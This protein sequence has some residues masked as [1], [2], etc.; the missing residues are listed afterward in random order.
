MDADDQNGQIVTNIL[1]LSLRNFVSN[2]RHQHRCNPCRRVEIFKSSFKPNDLW[3]LNLSN[4]FKL[5]KC[6]KLDNRMINFVGQQGVQ[7][8]TRLCVGAK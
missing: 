6:L 5:I 1:K 2:N 7:L 8:N 3:L 4:P